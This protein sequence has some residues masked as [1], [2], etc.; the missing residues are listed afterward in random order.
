MLALLAAPAEAL[1]EGIQDNS[2][3]LE[4][5]YNQEAGVVQ[6]ISVF[7]REREG[8]G[9][10]YGFTQEWPFPGLRH[11]ISYTLS[12]QHAGEGPTGV[13][14]GA[15]NYRYQLV[16]DG[17]APLAVS[18]RLSLLVP[19]G[20]ARDGL[21]TGGAGFQVAL[22]FSVVIGPRLATHGNAGFTHVFAAQDVAGN[23]SATSGVTLGQSLIF[24]VT[25]RFNL[26]LE[27][28]WTRSQS[29][30]GPGATR[31]RES[32][33][34]SPGIRWAHDF[35]GGL[36]IVPGLAVPIGLGESGGESSILVYL[37][38]EHPFRKPLSH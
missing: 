25:P 17:K 18:P 38:F 12:L 1:G 32:A 22:P 33:F 7:T 34:A 35:T 19:L 26:M 2:F 16:G 30:V 31:W 13:G 21:G 27:A 8:G 6:H 10:Q 37:S 5:A 11:Q 4:E 29:V 20:R 28:V 14:D 23:S 3:L 36:Q 15:L 9:W 24:T